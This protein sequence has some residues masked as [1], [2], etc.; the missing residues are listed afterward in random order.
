MKFTKFYIFDIMVLCPH[1]YGTNIQS[2]EK[3]LFALYTARFG[4]FYAILLILWI[5][6]PRPRAFLRTLWYYPH[7]TTAAGPSSNK[8]D[9]TLSPC[10]ATNSLRRRGGLRHDKDTSTGFYLQRQR[11]ICSILTIYP[12]I[13]NTQLAP[14]L[15]RISNYARCALHTCFATSNDT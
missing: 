14:R 7:F 12:H 8:G 4:G 15:S 1:L 9:T 11:C 2:W 5:T 6:I 13:I 3:V 10:P